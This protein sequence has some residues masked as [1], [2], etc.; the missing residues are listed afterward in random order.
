MVTFLYWPAMI[1]GFFIAGQL[2]LFFGM[3]WLV[4]LRWFRTH[5]LK[6]LFVPFVLTAL[7]TI[8]IYFL[9]VIQEQSYLN[10][11]LHPLVF[12]FRTTPLLWHKILFVFTAIYAIIFL[13]REEDLRKKVFQRVPLQ[14]R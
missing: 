5:S 1:R 2:I 13:W 8:D 10:S 6:S 12:W 3:L 9:S 7:L 4:F 11:T 14:R